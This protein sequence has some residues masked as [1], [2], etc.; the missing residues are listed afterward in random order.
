[1]KVLPFTCDRCKNDKSFSLKVTAE[2]TASL[3]VT[4]NRCGRIFQ[5]DNV[6]TVK[7]RG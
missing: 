2:G 5:L 4:C 3:F 6:A 1:M 7:A